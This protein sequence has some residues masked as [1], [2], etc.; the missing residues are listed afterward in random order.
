M[1]LLAF[2]FGS[3]PG[4]ADNPSRYA[5][6]AAS[7][8]AEILSVSYAEVDRRVEQLGDA[9]LAVIAFGIAAKS[10]RPRIEG[11]A[12]NRD[13]S[14]VPDVDG[15]VRQGPIEFGAPESLPGDGIEGL[16]AALEPFDVE[17][18]DDAGGYLC[19]HLYWRLLR[20][21]QSAAVFIHLP[22]D[23]EPQWY[24]ALGAAC[25]GVISRD[26]SQA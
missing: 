14:S 13:A 3:F 6:F 1:K 20:R 4:V 2:G 21:P 5:A 10:S 8:E 12:R 7:S 22:P 9:P 11:V 18:S 24:A 19:N 25:A 23:R 17:L 26:R 16:L 15:V